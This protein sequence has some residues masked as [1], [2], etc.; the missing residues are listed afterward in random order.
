MTWRAEALIQTARGMMNYLVVMLGQ[1]AFQ[2]LWYILP[3]VVGGLIAFIIYKKKLGKEYYWLAYAAFLAFVCYYANY[4]SATA[5]DAISVWV[6]VLWFFHAP[7]VV[8]A[9]MIA[10]LL[11]LMVFLHGFGYGRWAQKG[12]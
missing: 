7:I 9:L 2:L 8:P 6:E 5:R 4:L 10:P 12:T 3:F 1:G 11:L